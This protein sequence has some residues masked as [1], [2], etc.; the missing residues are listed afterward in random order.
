[1]VISSNEL[2]KQHTTFK[3]G[4]KLKYFT[5]AE[6]IQDIKDAIDFAKGQGLPW[7]VLGNGSNILGSDKGYNGLVIKTTSL[8]G[9]EPVGQCGLQVMAGTMLSV[10]AAYACEHSLTG[11]EFAGGIPGTVG[12]GIYMNCGAY[13]GEISQVIRKVIYLDSCGELQE[14][15]ADALEFSYRHSI[16]KDHP[17]WVI[18]G[19]QLELEPGDK[20]QI[21]AK[22]RELNSA[23]REKQPLE[24]PSAGSTFKRPE[25]HFA[26]KL[27]DDC[28]LKGF[29]VGGA[30]VSEKHGGFVINKG[31]ATAADVLE[32]IE[33]IKDAVY[34]KTGVMLDCEIQFLGE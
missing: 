16:F 13:G 6:T 25:G 14:L 27:I 7:R 18:I 21:E 8:C 34:H 28:G 2:L 4:G 3:I 20:G 5:Q 17:D 26:A 30:Q 24:Y 32:L 1:M 9:I 11:L 23:R 19:A 33:K 31:G 12:G 15:T 29:T 22:M 10:L